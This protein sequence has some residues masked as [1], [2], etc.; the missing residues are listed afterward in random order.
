MDVL[1]FYQKKKKN[2]YIYLK[3][4]TNLLFYNIC[5]FKLYFDCHMLGRFP[6]LMIL[7]VVIFFTDIKPSITKIIFEAWILP[8]PY[9]NNTF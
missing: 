3:T 7:R 1:V 9:F 8:N 5:K 4:Y 6:T 2:Y